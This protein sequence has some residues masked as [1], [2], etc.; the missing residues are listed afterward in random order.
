M[1]L[2]TA[3]PEI[4]LWSLAVAAI[5]LCPLLQE[6]SSQHTNVWQPALQNITFPKGGLCCLQS[7][8]LEWEGLKGDN[9]CPP[10]KCHFKQYLPRLGLMGQPA[11]AVI[12]SPIYRLIHGWWKAEFKPKSSFNNHLAPLLIKNTP[13][14][15]LAQNCHATTYHELETDCLDT[16][17]V[18]ELSWFVS[19]SATWNCSLDYWDSCLWLP[20]IQLSK[21]VLQ[22]ERWPVGFAVSPHWHCLDFLSYEQAGAIYIFFRYGGTRQPVAIWSKES[23]LFVPRVPSQ[24]KRIVGHLEATGKGML[25]C[26]SDSGMENHVSH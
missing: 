18:Q 7:S 20:G 16:S 24:R 9:F 26:Y 25:F 19:G 6:A 11:L 23:L 3:G 22:K 10:F 12:L 21:Q 14:K 2:L 5:P 15:L 13:D 17:S 8:C 4:F 1:I